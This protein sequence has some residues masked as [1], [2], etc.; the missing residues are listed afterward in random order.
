M[1]FIIS[2][3][4]TTFFKT[5]HTSLIIAWWFSLICIPL[6]SINGRALQGYI[7][8][9]FSSQQ[10]ALLLGSILVLLSLKAVLLQIKNHG[11]KRLWHLLWFI[12]LFIVLPYYMPIIEERLHFIVFGLYGYLSMLVLPRP[13]AYIACQ[14]LGMGDELL[15]WFLPDRVGDWRDVQFNLLAAF[16]ATAFAQLS[17]KNQRE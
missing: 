8:S 10:L 3:L 11:V 7:N 16:A 9:N 5:P 12:P 13:T 17:L 14:L 6:L 2:I 15:Q 1:G 4:K